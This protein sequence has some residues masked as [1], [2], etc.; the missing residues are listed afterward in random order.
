VTDP[1]PP[2]EPCPAYPELHALA[3]AMRPDWSPD[4]LHDAMTAAHQA[5]WPWKDVFREVARLVL[6]GDEVPATLRNSA[7]RP[8]GRHDPG[9]YERGGALWRA[10]NAEVQARITGPQARLA[11]VNDYGQETR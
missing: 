11:E 7:R 9:A 3:C 5:G 1:A 8:G 4:E 10:A 6:A 2:F